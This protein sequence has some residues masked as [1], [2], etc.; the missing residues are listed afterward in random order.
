MICTRR[1]AIKLAFAA[2]A[3]GGAAALAS[4]GSNTSIVGT[5][6]DEDGSYEE[7]GWTLVF[8]DDGTIVEPDGSSLTSLYGNP[9][10][11]EK[12]PIE[13]VQQGGKTYG[14]FHYTY[15]NEDG[16]MTYRG[17][18]VEGNTAYELYSADY[19]ADFINTGALPATNHFEKWTRK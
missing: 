6:I 5:W 8:K 9:V 13:T 11:W 18:A 7:G 4:C 15:L 17:Y 1:S 10:K 16:G 3:C 14:L 19:F 2:L 12:Y